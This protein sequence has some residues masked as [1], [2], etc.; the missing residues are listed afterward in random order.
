MFV[1]KAVVPRPEVRDAG[2]LSTR[3]R[4]IFRAA[5]TM[6]SVALS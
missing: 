6:E 3:N 2:V 5:D 1:P 4:A